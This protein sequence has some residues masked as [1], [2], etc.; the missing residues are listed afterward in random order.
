MIKLNNYFFLIN[1]LKKIL[2]TLKKIKI[3]YITILY[4]EWKIKCY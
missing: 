1:I 3:I 2:I 4:I